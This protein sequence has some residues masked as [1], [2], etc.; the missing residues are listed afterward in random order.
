MRIPPNIKGAPGKMT[1]A[2]TEVKY[3]KRF[4]IISG[5][6]IEETLRRLVSDP[7]NSP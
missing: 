3:A 5:P 2:F 1:G 7:C 6:N 4:N